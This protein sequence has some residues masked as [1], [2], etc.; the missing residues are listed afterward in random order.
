MFYSQGQVRTPLLHSQKQPWDRQRSSVLTK[1][2]VLLLLGPYYSV[3]EPL[4]GTTWPAPCISGASQVALVVKNLPASSGD[5]RD[6]GSI[7]GSRRSPGEGHGNPLQ[8]S[9]LENPMDRGSWQASVD[10]VTQSQTQLKWLS[11]YVPCISLPSLTCKQ[12]PTLSPPP[13]GWTEHVE[14]E[15]RMDSRIERNLESL[16]DLTE[17]SPF[18]LLQLHLIAWIRNKIWLC[19]GSW[20]LGV[21]CFQGSFVMVLDSPY[22]EPNHVASF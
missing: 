15:G 2:F 20:N 4:G 17:L 1:I 11:T 9:C 13:P 7:T 14:N 12:P 18:H 19:L 6:V 5:V 21:V 3:P 10:R 8:Y 22:C 16:N